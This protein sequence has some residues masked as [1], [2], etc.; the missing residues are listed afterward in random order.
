MHKLALTLLFV[1]VAPLAAQAQIYARIRDITQLHGTMANQLTG[2]GLVTGL[3]GTGSGDKATRQAMANFIRRYGLNIQDSDLTSGNF[4][5][6]SVGALLPP[7]AH[8]GQSLDVTVSMQGDGSSLYGGKLERCF[9]EGVDGKTYAMAEGRVSVGGVSASGPS[10]RVNVNHVNVGRVLNGASVVAE[11]A[12]S[13]LSERGDLELRLINPSFATAASV[14]NGINSVLAER[15]CRAG[16]VDPGLVRINIPAELQNNEAALLLVNAIGDVRIAVENPASVVIDETTGL[17]LAG[18]GVMISPCVV[19]LSDLTIT[20]VSEDVVE[21]PLP[22]P[23]LGTT[24]KVNR[25]RIDV[26]TDNTEFKP[27]SGGATVDELLSNLK[28]LALTPRQL[29]TV[30]RELKAGGY[31]HAELVLR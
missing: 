19:A 18:A 29:V 31:L 6:V 25:T 28:A 15:G 10:A 21:Q 16:P 26:Q 20:V 3:K 23:N 5:L 30:F 17:V 27:V 4:A 7:F 13:F 22:G 24:E 12:T 9:L 2:Q 11:V 14:A 1:A 8:E